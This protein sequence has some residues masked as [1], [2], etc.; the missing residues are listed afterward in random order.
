MRTF[1]FLFISVFVTSSLLAQNNEDEKAIHDLVQ[2]MSKAW[3][4]G[5][6]EQFASVFADQHDYIVWN[7]YYM[8]SFNPQMNAQTH[9]RIFEGI[10]KNTQ[11]HVVIDKIKF[12]KEDVAMIHVLGA[13]SQKGEE[14]PKDPQVLWTSLL[15]K[16]SGDWKIISFH[17][18]DLEVFQNEGM[19]KGAPIPVEKMYSSWYAIN[20]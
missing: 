4:D 17:N 14:R 15:T 7:G 6:G 18:L 16:E 9:Q 12:V 8:K 5:N 13:I 19:K 11:N 20:E 10:Y 2:T 1:I 3:T